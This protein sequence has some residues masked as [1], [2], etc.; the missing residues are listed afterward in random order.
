MPIYKKGRTTPLLYLCKSKV[1]P[2]GS[3]TQ[4]KKLLEEFNVQV[5]EWKGGLEYDQ[6]SEE[7]IIKDCDYMLLIGPRIAGGHN[8]LVGKGQMLQ[9]NAFTRANRYP[10]L[11]IIDE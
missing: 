1:S 9:A 8:L 5:V 2:P 11:L 7:K 4:I 3:V 6:E 10:N